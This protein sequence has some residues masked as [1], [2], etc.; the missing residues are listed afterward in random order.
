MILDNVWATLAVA[1]LLA[2]K[3]L[4]QT[5]CQPVQIGGRN[6]TCLDTATMLTE[7]RAILHGTSTKCFT[8]VSAKTGYFFTSTEVCVCVCVCVS[9]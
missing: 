7:K 1:I 8:L 5:A 6:L 3:A 9:K 2:G 4:S